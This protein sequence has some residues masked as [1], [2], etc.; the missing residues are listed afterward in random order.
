MSIIFC[1]Y[2]DSLP[3]AQISV[4]LFDLLSST[5]QATVAHGPID[6][7]HRMIIYDTDDNRKT[8]ASP[9]AN[10]LA[11]FAEAQPSLFKAGSAEEG[12]FDR[13]HMDKH[14]V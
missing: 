11:R 9:N 5:V 6:E 2:T 4:Q 7:Y 8:C 10:E 13:V 14:N 1:K 12:F 3:S